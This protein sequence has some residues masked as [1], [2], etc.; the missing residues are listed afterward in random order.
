MRPRLQGVSNF[1]N[2]KG[3]RKAK[4]KEREERIYYND[5]LQNSSITT[6]GRKKLGRR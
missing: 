2:C 5:K 4:E 1:F 3:K 6:Q